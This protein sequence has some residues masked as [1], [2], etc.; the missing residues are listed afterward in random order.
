MNN[1]TIF[2]LSSGHGKSGV[3]VIRISGDNL[4]TMASRFIGRRDI[5]PRHAYFANL[6]DANGDLIDQCVIIYFATPHSFT[7]TDVIEIQCHGADAVIQKIFSYLAESHARMAT[8][9]EFSR[10][11]FYNGKMDLADVD[12]LAALLDAT[13]ERQRA[14]ALQ[15]MMGRDSEIY[16]TWRAQMVEI[17][18]YAA[19][20]LDY[21]DDELPANIGDKIRARTQKLYDEINDALARYAAAR[22]IRSG[23]NITLAGETNVGKSSIFNYMVGANRAIVSDIPGTTRDVVSASMDIDGYLVNLSDTAGLRDTDDMIEKIGIDKTHAEIENADLV[24]RV[25]AENTNAT[26][27]DNELLVIN[28]SDTITE[29]TIPNAIYVSAK[30]GAGM[31]TL[32]KEITAC[33]HKIMGSAEN[34]LAINART[35]QCLTDAATELKNAIDIAGDNYDI[36]AEHTRRAA[37]AIGKILGTITAAEVMDATF[38]Q[39][40][41]GK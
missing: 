19:A 12:G 20:I 15:S 37:D 40:C 38:S 29:Q 24:I 16:D 27:A 2:A 13:T 14:S 31:D 5:K 26:V 3:A 41:L 36:F 11:A 23:F 28:K 10:R 6:A 21:A 18:A 33:M 4:G 9:G 17:S 1:D 34:M 22:A 32:M 39:L 25:Y 35:R 8:P 30:T 7:G